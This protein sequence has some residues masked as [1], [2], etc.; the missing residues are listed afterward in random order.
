MQSKEIKLA[1]N[2]ELDLFSKTSQ[3]QEAISN[4]KERAS[5]TENTLEKFMERMEE[6]LDD[7][8]TNMNKKFH[9]ME[10]KIDSIVKKQITLESKMKGGWLVICVL[11]AVLVSIVSFF[12]TLHDI[13]TK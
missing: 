13:F 7:M 11:G 4:L 6:K 1:S 8:N 5:K 2:Q 12:N 10:L 3:N 9:E